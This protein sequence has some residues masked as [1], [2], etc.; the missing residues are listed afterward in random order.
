MWDDLPKLMYEGVMVRPARDNYGYNPAYSVVKSEQAGTLARMN[1]GVINGPSEVSCSIH[2][3]DYLMQ[4]WWDTFYYY[5][6][7]E[8]SKRFL[9]ELLVNG[10]IKTHVAQIVNT[11]SI[12]TVGWKGD[13]S[14]KLQVVPTRNRCFDISLAALLPCYGSKTK[15]MICQVEEV[16]K[17]FNNS[18]E[19]E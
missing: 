17:M 8:G 2:L 14:L 15:Q 5:T 11:P 13:V 19:P 9:V 10:I 1:R 3:K 12:S 6:I 7:A 16:A 4:Q 18:W